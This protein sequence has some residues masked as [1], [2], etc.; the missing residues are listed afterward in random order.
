MSSIFV[1]I[2]YEADFKKGSLHTSRYWKIIRLII[3]SG[4]IY[5]AALVFEITFYVL[6]SN[7]FYIVYDPIA[8]LT[9]NF[10]YLISAFNF[11]LCLSS[12]DRPDHDYRDVNSWT[13]R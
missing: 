7:A 10:S 6:H 8:Q 3:E 13:H 2:A 5:S 11:N 12:G 9:V 4:A 1:A